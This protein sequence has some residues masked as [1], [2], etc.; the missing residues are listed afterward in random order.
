M[1]QDLNIKSH[2]L[3]LRTK[4]GNL[5]SPICIKAKLDPIKVNNGTH[6]VYTCI[7]LSYSLGIISILFIP[8]LTLIHLTTPISLI[9]LTT[10]L[11]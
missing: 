2:K 11:I 6:T 5:H 10:V 3:S 1:F 9:Q 4:W 8:Q 7:F